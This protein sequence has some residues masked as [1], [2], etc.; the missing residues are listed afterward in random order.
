MFQLEDKWKESDHD[1]SNFFVS[2][3]SEPALCLALAGRCGLFLSQREIYWQ[4]GVSAEVLGSLHVEASANLAGPSKLLLSSE[5]CVGHSSPAACCCRRSGHQRIQWGCPVIEARI[6]TARQHYK[7]RWGCP[8]RQ[9]M[10]WS[11]MSSCWVPQCS[12]TWRS[13]FQSTAPAQVSWWSYLELWS[14]SQRVPVCHLL[15]CDLSSL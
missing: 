4:V 5:P 14:P 10:L 9:V 12:C 3:L 13:G 6:S 1:R 8:S 7:Y 11:I 15:N 2:G